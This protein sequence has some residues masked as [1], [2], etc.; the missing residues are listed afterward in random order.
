MSEPKIATVSHPILTRPPILTAGQITPK[1]VR[2]FENHCNTFFINAKDGVEDNEKV[3]RIIGCFENTL[4]DDWALCDSE[5]LMALTFPEF[6]KQFR[7]RWLPLNWEQAVRTQMLN[8]RLDPSQRFDAWSDQILSYNVSL[9]NTTSHMSDAQLRIQLEAALDEELRTMATDEKLNEIADF[10]EWMSKL[11][12]IDNRR[13]TERKRMADFWDNRSAKRQNTGTRYPPA[14]NVNRSSFTRGSSAPSTS[15]PSLYPPKLTDDERRLLHDHE[16]CLKCRTFYA[17]HR[18]GACTIT[19]SG[20]DYKQRTLQDALRARAT[21]G[22]TRPTT[23]PASAPVAAI[24]E[25]VGDAPA[26]TDLV[27]AIFPSTTIAADTSTSDAS[28]TSLSSV[29]APLKEK[30]LVWEC[31]LTNPTDSVRVKRALP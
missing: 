14:N 11:T 3:K 17:G 26:E 29:S 30:H 8:S 23:V 1:A 12:R 28:E 24:T 22:N 16:G 20:K 15:T 10:H 7:A 4:V 5:R 6:M 21:K 13:Q 2:D 19:L 9:R 31:V 25:F 27:A 18:A